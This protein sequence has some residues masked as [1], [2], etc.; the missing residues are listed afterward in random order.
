[1]VSKIA[2]V[3]MSWE[4]MGKG[5]AVEVLLTVADGCDLMTVVKKIT[6]GV[7]GAMAIWAAAGSETWNFDRL[8]EIGGHKTTLLGHPRVID[9]PHGKAIEFNGVDDAVYL[10]VHPLAGVEAYTWEVIFRP[11]KG[12][13]PE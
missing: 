8:D 1:M 11:D 13:A 10:G 6:L 9:T 4:V 7:M 5:W 12:G 2:I 3:S